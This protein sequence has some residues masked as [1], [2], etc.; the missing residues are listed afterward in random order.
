MK[1]VAKI[2]KI[3]DM[4]VWYD[5]LVFLVS[6]ILLIALFVFKADHVGVGHWFLFSYTVLITVFQ[7]FRLL[8]AIISPRVLAV[9]ESGHIDNENYTPS[10]TIVIP[11]KNEG[12]DIA[13]TILKS[14]EADYPKDLLE[15]I[16][17]ND[18]S[19]DDTLSEIL[20]VKESHPELIIIDWKENRGKREGM[21][22]GFRIAKGEIVVQLD[23]DS[24]IEPKKFRDLIRPFANPIVGAVCAH[25]DVANAD[26]N[27]ITKM[28]AGYYFIAFRILKAAESSL[29]SVFCCSGCSSAYRKEIVMPIMEEWLAEQFMGV[30]VKHGDDRSLTG[31]VLK[32]GYR[33]I[34]THKAQ[35]Y[36]IAPENMKQLFR[37]QIRWKKSWVS[38][39]FFT[40]KYIFKTDPFVG[41]FYFTPL[42]LISFLTPL[43]AL[44]NIYLLSIWRGSLPFAYLTGGLIVTLLYMLYAARH[45]NGK[46]KYIGHFLAWQFLTVTVFC[47]FIFYSAFTFRNQS[48]AT[49]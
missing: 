4:S 1:K 3:E 10:V 23:S 12:K 18:G 34:Y 31:W 21:A 43:V 48:W 17:I 47:Y 40:F 22:A 36:T 5:G 46:K 41:V 33:T 37:Q 26:K 38:N 44:F 49:R 2:F 16:V 30:T 8:A 27:F 9:I 39:A 6:L 32:Q 42:V 15:V 19:T 29:C 7:L 25:A 28:Q 35:A 13:H 20:K 45:T 11:C 24:Y 14:F